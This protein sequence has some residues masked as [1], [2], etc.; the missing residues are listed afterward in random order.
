MTKDISQ[1]SLEVIEKREKTV[2]SLLIP[3]EHWEHFERLKQDSGK[4]ST[5]FLKYLLE[6]HQNGKNPELANRVK[7]TTQYQDGGLKLKKYN[8]WVDPLIWHRF[9]TLARF[10]GVSMCYLFTALLCTVKKLG[11]DIK[12]YVPLLAILH[13][14]VRIPFGI[15]IRRYRVIE[16]DTS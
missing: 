2:V 1:P 15:A 8:F 5:E 6:R 11:T 7:L 4:S 12:K 14:K 16:P 10:Y 13:E 9:K 3:S